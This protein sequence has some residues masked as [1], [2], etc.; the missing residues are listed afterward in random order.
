MKLGRAVLITA[1][2][3]VIAVAVTLLFFNGS[4]KDYRNCVALMWDRK[5]PVE[6]RQRH[7]EQTARKC[8][9]DR[10]SGG[11]RCDPDA[12]MRDCEASAKETAKMFPTYRFD[13]DN[14]IGGDSLAVGDIGPLAFGPPQENPCEHLSLEELRRADAEASSRDKPPR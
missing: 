4:T 9:K 5:H 6:V 3:A 13:W 7:I 1:G 2:A 11:T 12:L 14:C 8:E 10:L